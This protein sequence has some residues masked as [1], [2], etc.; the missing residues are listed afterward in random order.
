MLNIRLEDLMQVTV[1]DGPRAVQIWK[2][3]VSLTSFLQSACV[4]YYIN[5][6]LTVTLTL[7]WREF[8]AP[9]CGFNYS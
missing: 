7:K 4:T 9:T 3:S 6:L 8:A 5:E 2:D 1:L